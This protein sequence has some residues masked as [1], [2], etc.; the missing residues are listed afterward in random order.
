MISVTVLASVGFTSPLGSNLATPLSGPTI[1]PLSTDP[2]PEPCGGTIL[3]LHQQY[4][5]H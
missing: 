1:E 5:M 3:T 4:G 2:S